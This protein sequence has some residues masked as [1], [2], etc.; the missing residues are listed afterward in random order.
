MTAIETLWIREMKRFF[1]AKSRILG[2]LSMPVIWLAIMGV[3]L[4]ASVTLPGVPQGY[5]A[6]I[7]PGIIGM[8]LL[9]T[10]IFSGISVIWDKQFGFMKEILVAPISRTALV[11]GKVAGSVTISMINGVII[12][13]ISVLIGALPL[14][15]EGL[16][17]ALVLMALVSAVFVALGLVI[18]SRLDNMEGFQMIMSF[19]IMPIFF[20]SGAFFPVDR[21]PGWMQALAAADPLY[22]G[23]DGL[24]GA[25]LGVSSYSALLD[26]AVLLGWTIV[27]VGIAVRAYQHLRM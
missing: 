18:A 11:L 13:A 14:H 27:L 10:S 23:V 4:D 7:A 22:Y 12:L 2:N 24:R 15:L 3:G 25:L 1:R 8:T 26:I 6:F 5:L 19:L 17:L 9:F 20:L 16:L 21:A